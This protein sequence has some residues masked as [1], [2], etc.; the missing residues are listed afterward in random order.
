[1]LETQTRTLTRSLTYRLSA[2]LLTIGLTYAWTGSLAQSTG[3]STFLH[4][5]LSLDYYIHERV[6]LRVKW[7]LKT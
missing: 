2:W 7:G 5:I 6:W 1:M 3:F 4:G